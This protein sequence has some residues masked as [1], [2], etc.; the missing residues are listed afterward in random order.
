[1]LAAATV[2]GLRELSRTQITP[3]YGTTPNTT[4]ADVP[5]LGAGIVQ[6]TSPDNPLKLRVYNSVNPAHLLSTLNATDGAAFRD[7]Y[8][9]AGTFLGRAK[10]QY[11]LMQGQVPWI[12]SDSNFLFLGHLGDLPIWFNWLNTPYG[13]S[14]NGAYLRGTAYS[15]DSTHPIGWETDRAGAVSSD[16]GLFF[17]WVEKKTAHPVTFEVRLR[18][19]GHG[20]SLLYDG[21]PAVEMPRN[22][23]SAD[24][25]AI[26]NG[27]RYLWRGGGSLLKL[28][29]I[30]SNYE[31]TL[32]ETISFDN[33][34]SFVD[35]V[36]A[37]DGLL[38]G[39][40]TPPG[41]TPYQ[42]RLFSRIPVYTPAT[43]TLASVV[44]A[45]ATR[46][47]LAAGDLDTAALTDTVEG[48]LIPRPMTAR[49][50][51]E[52]LRQAYF[53]DGVES[54][55][56][57]KFVKRGGASQA[58]IGSDELGARE[59]GSEAQE[60]I[61]ITRAQELE[62]PAE[63]HVQYLDLDNDYL[64]GSQ[65]ARRLTTQSKN[66]IRIDLPLALSSAK[67]ARVADVLMR[68]T[69]VERHRFS[70]ALTR[71]YA[72][73]DPSDNIT[74]PTPQGQ[75]LA[76]LTRTDYGAGGVLACEALAD[77]TVL[78]SSSVVGNDSTVN[79]PQTLA[80][81]GPTQA[82][83][84][85]TPMLRD[86]DD[87]PG[88]YIVAA[89]YL[90]GWKGTAIYKSAD[91]GATWDPALSLLSGATL[92]YATGVLADFTGANVWDLGNRINVKLTTPGGALSSTTELAV[93]A[94]ANAFALG[95]HGRWEIILF[96]TAT[97]EADGTYTLSKLLRGRRGTEW[98]QAGHLLNDTFVLLT[99]ATVRRLSHSSSEI[100]LARHYRAVSI[101]ASLE[102][103]E[104]KA[105]TNAAV[106]LECYSPVLVRGYRE[107]DND[108][109]IDWVRRTRIAGEW[110]DYV[111]VAL[112]E[113][114]ESYEVEIYSPSLLTLVRTLT[115]L[116]TPTVTY[117][118][119]QQTT[120]F[121]AAQDTLGVK[122]YQ[123]S[124]TVGRGY[125]ASAVFPYIA[126][127]SVPLTLWNLLDKSAAITL[128]ANEL[129]ATATTAAW[130]TV[131]A[132][133][134]RSSGKYYFEVRIDATDAGRNHEVGICQSATS[135]ESYLFAST[136]L[137]YDGATGN[138]AKDNVNSGAPGVTYTSA[139]VVGV[140]L[141]AGAGKMRF[142]KNNTWLASGD[143]GNGT[144]P[145]Y[146]GLSGSW[147][148]A[149][150]PFE[151]NAAA[152]ARFRSAHFTYTPPSGFAAWGS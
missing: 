51:L 106:G 127:E 60:P 124:A 73:L 22:L 85:D 90:G 149:F 111:D 89:G 15:L 39:H 81:V 103:A 87:D 45:L 26:E 56:K 43:V 12:A 36:S 40:G 55:G 8:D 49:A 83:Y 67:A 139:D 100:G 84:L 1:M 120:D 29:R 10:F 48:Y 46:T 107:S 57:V 134:S 20:M 94:G 21:V 13:I 74:V 99:S 38:M 2:S 148:P 69:W 133:S 110:R 143:P 101:G 34:S 9:L 3:D 146:S 23:N 53:F 31:F 62:L 136:G 78:Y 37:R 41:A 108:W 82:Q 80:Q 70:F 147:F 65:E 30:E 14:V 33:S 129:K 91:N 117:T 97:L 61:R 59:Y 86:A 114:S 137:G 19:Y 135:L 132:S 144:N 79:E 11:P 131:R 4:T 140:A 42:L 88:F 118:S 96:Q 104:I 119:A 123:R 7:T 138:F 24:T 105:F 5:L 95:V 122:V 141:D 112:G 142:A 17:H 64:P 25:V 76:R 47:G 68:N 113:S 128:S 93:Y 63:I 52:Q 125:P 18:V 102:S 71:K 150:S 35:G 54:E 121:G 58:T 77:D 16:G 130:K 27:G 66:Q 109:L 72:H 98:A 6:L 126:P 116:S 115:G 151:I 92:G 50:A 152:T 145:A 44:S 28:Y 32:L 75:A